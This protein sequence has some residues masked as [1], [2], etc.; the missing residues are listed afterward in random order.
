MIS[1][2]SELQPFFTNFESVYYEDYRLS[3]LFSLNLRNVQ[4]REGVVLDDLSSSS[5]SRGKT[6]HL[7]GH[8]EE[9]FVQEFPLNTERKKLKNRK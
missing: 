2:C 8:Y 1:N 5:E 3:K 6:D 4:Q 7:P 9:I